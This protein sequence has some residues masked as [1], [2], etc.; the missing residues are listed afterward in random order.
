MEILRQR[1]AASPTLPRVLPFIIFVVLTALQD[2]FGDAGRYWIYF[3][4]TIVGI[5][6]IWLVRPLVAEMKWAVS[7]DAV[8]VGIAVFGIW[9]GLD[10]FYPKFLSSGS[11]WNPF[12][13]FGENAAL[14]WFF[15][16]VR[17]A[18][19]TLLAPMIEEVFY[20]SFAYRW[21]VRPEFQ[22]VP[23]NQFNG[24]AFFMT[25]ALFALAHANEWMPALL[26]AFAY[27]WLVLRKNRLGDAMVAH[28]IT[29]LLL[30]I[31][32][33]WRGDWKFW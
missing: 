16:I 20:R 9:V 3:G 2:K 14:A 26:C 19:S 6:L 13:T 8:V 22:T 24:K 23:F 12:T 5:W 11:A 18:G 27:Q 33:V 10:R 15:V 21:I 28:A 29:N 4:K 30:G 31:W 25:A 1:L 7:R 17:I 32:V